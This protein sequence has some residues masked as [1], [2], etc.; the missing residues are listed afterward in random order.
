[1][2]LLANFSCFT[3]LLLGLTQYGGSLVHGSKLS[4]RDYLNQLHIKTGGRWENSTSTHKRPTAVVEAGIVFGTTTSLPTANAV[5]NQFL[6]VP[7]AKSPPERFGLPEP[8]PK[9]RRPVNA[10]RW[11]P[12]CIQ[13]FRYPEARSEFTQRL[14]NTPR[15]EESEDCLYLNIYAPAEEAGGDGRAVLF[16]IFGG[17]L[18]FGHAGQPDYDGSAFAAYEDVIVVTANYRTNVFGFPNSPEI[19]VVKNNLGFIDQRYALE[20]VQ[21][22][23]HAF[24][25]D[26]DKVTIF[27]ESAG[28][29][30]IDAHLTA[31]S[32]HSTPPFRAAILQ[33]G[34]QSYRPTPDNSSLP[35]WYNLTTQ[36]GCPGSY[37]NNLTCV[38]AANASAIQNII[39]KDTLVFSPIIDNV[40]W[41]SRPA[42]RRMSGNIARIPVLGGTNAHEGRT[43]VINQTNITTFLTANLRDT[44]PH[45]IPL[46]AELYLPNSTHASNQSNY[47]AIAEVYTDWIF[48]CPQSLWAQASAATSIPTWRYY[49]NASFPNLLT[50]AN[51]TYPLGA[52]HGSEIQVLFGTYPHENIT[53]QQHALS[54][55]L[56]GTWSRFA[57]NPLAGPGWNRVGTGR[58]AEVVDGI[59]GVQ[60]GG[61]WS[62]VNGTLERGDGWDL[63][64]LGNVGSV[65]GSGVTVVESKVVDK[66]CEVWR[67]VYE[68]LAG[69]DGMPPLGF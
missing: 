18:Q 11:R 38:R 49:F 20:W 4:P 23:I 25:G 65:A 40:T 52:F 43:F 17:S 31:Y 41:V 48:Q 3:S 19:P 66:R 32:Q 59:Y 53:V 56:R 57:K 55:F 67:E 63:A 47:D 51:P 45:L 8:V 21:R 64:V 15:P 12:A 27:G 44:A 39:N 14:F 22:N 54:H 58:T 33:S 9:S 60:R 50:R 46:I 13:Q 28:G 68:G 7:F 36:L 37:S 29:F 62:G 26:P 10:T 34:Q 69:K 16:W 30:S 42:Y 35:Q 1:M 5:V 2:R 24:G 61:V 6:G